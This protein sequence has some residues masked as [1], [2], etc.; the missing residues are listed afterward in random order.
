MNYSMLARAK[1]ARRCIKILRFRS[2]CRESNG[3]ESAAKVALFQAEPCRVFPGRTMLSAQRPALL[4]SV[5]AELL[6]GATRTGNSAAKERVHIR[7]RK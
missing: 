4:V 6:Y 2:L 5:G 3:G 7:I 1:P